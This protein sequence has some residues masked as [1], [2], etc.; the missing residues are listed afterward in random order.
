[1]ENHQPNETSKC[2]TP[3]GLYLGVQKNK[4]IIKETCLTLRSTNLA[5]ENPTFGDVSSNKNDD[6][7]LPG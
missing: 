3:T 1:M 4:Q 5:M 2:R 7:P 6:F